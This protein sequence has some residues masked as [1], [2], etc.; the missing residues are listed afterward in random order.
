[1]AAY[2]VVAIGVAI[3]HGHYLSLPFLV[4]VPVRLRL[5]RRALA[6][7]VPLSAFVARPRRRR[8]AA[9]SAILDLLCFRG[10]LP[11]LG[12]VAPMT[13]AFIAACVGVLGATDEDTT[14]ARRRIAIAAVVAATV[15]LVVACG[16]LSAR[17]E[18]RW[19]LERSSS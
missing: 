7:P 9:L 1:M 2:F 5:R 16:L 6:A 4:P 11:G 17:S 19:Q 14:V 10:L 18:A 3:D 13:L 15:T 12:A 8:L